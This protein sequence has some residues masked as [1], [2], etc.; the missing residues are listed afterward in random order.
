MGKHLDGRWVFPRVDENSRAR[1]KPLP[2]A[3]TRRS[4]RFWLPEGCCEV[5]QENYSCHH[6]SPA[7]PDLGWPDIWKA[8][9]HLKDLKNLVKSR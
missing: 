7:A 8:G 3:R 9:E 4:E 6:I 5:A 1:V 2:E